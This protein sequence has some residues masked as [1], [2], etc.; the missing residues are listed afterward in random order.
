MAVYPTG[1]P[2]NSDLY[3]ALDNFGTTL[4]GAIDNAQTT[5]TLNST[6]G[7]PT[8]GILT[9]ESEK[10]KYTGIS[11]SDLTGCTRGF[12]STS[13]A[14]HVNGSSV[15]FNVVEEHHNVLKD[16]IIAVAVDNRNTFTADLNDSITATA[17]AT[18]LKE[19]LDMIVTRIKE[20]LGTADWKDTVVNALSAISGKKTVATGNAYK[21][22]TTGA[23]GDLQE[24]T[25]TALRAVVTDANG[26][27]TAA[28]TTAAEIGYVNGV[29]SAIQAQLN[30]KLPQEGSTFRNRIING[31]MQI[32]QRQAGTVFTLNTAGGNFVSD[33]WIVYGA[34]ADGVLTFQRLSTTPPEG[35]THYTQIKTTTADASIGAAQSYSI[36]Q[37]IEGTNTIDFKW[38]LSSAKT[39]A[40]SFWVRSSLTG[41]FSGSLRNNALN[42]SYPFS[43]TVDSANTWEHKTIIVVGETTGTWLTTTGIGVQVLFDLGSSTSYRG[44][45]NTW[46]NG[47]YVGVTGAV[48]LVGTLN[49]TL[50]LTGVQVEIG[51]VATA[52]ENRSL[53]I[54]LALCQRYFEKSYETDV[55]IGT[56]TAGGRTAVGFSTVTGTPS[57]F[58]TIYFKVSKG[59]V[60]TV[61][62]YAYTLGT[63]GKTE[64]LSGG[65]ET[66]PSFG[67]PSHNQGTVLT[68]AVTTGTYC[69]FHWSAQAEI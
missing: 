51:S 2:S 24:T 63:A 37:K 50:D 18:S 69:I 64:N 67:T 42:R 55:A 23:T 35:F 54:E 68:G 45:A 44:T 6:V 29:T 56:V 12:S 19:R 30:S 33:R 47:N 40:F 14:S 4:N 48:S 66:T 34:A 13:A 53:G 28:T 22:E 10:V 59:T 16:E 46:T 25:V 49:A 7:L 52:F 41:V 60:P 57:Y 17:T 43:Y 58:E 26:L 20:I 62:T 1:T 39:I 32:N 27:P 38:G 5:I 65:V 11:G 8:V 3:V 15:W 21:F 61:N 9:I 36:M 31:D